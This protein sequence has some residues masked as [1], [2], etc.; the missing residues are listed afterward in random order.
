MDFDWSSAPVP[1][2]APAVALRVVFRVHADPTYDVPKNLPLARE[3]VALRTYSGQGSLTLRG[4]APLTVL[5]GTVLLF[6]HRDVRHYACAADHWH[7]F[8]FE[9][10]AAEWL[11]EPAL[12]ILHVEFSDR[13]LAWCG[14]C[15]SALRGGQEADHR[16]ATSLFS[17]LLSQW[18]LA[19]H[20][21]NDRHPGRLAIRQALRYL[22]D[23]LDHPPAMRVLA[24]QTGFSE[25]R[26]RQLFQLE[27]GLSPKQHHTRLRM[28]R[29]EAMLISTSYPIAR[30][31]DALGYANAF[32][33]SRHFRQETGMSPTQFRQQAREP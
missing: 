3:W 4:G 26:L 9:F 14:M 10:D 16:L 24:T 8:W 6:P 17:V 32:H 12:S 5:P 27:T 7:F 19:A 25:R 31:A 30:I 22:E 20:E 11:D 21:S 23:N 18:Q 29:A 13:E 33:F 28:E 15:L 2:K 1:Q